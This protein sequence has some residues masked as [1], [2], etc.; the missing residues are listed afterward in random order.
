VPAAA[1]AAPRSRFVETTE[2]NFHRVPSRAGTERR[3]VRSTPKNT[4]SHHGGWSMSQVR[5]EAQSNR[6]SRNGSAVAADV[7]PSDPEALRARL[8]A[9]E[10][11][12]NR[13]LLEWV[14]RIVDLAKPDRVWWCD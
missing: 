1:I 14:G 13:P 9:P 2:T 11:M 3:V 10:W 6:T 7:A 12:R 5:A 8:G 4:E